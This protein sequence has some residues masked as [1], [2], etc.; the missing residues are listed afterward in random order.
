ML[1]GNAAAGI[2]DEIFSAEMTAN[3]IQCGSCGREG[4]LG[5][6]QAFTQA[7]G[8]V[9]RCPACENILLRIVQLPEKIY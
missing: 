6:L 1:D 5:T 4:E 2:L 9:L 3:W 7:P 8:L